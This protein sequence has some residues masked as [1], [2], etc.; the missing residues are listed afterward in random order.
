MRER[1]YDAPILFQIVEACKCGATFR[2]N[3]AVGEF[4]RRKAR[5]QFRD[6]HAGPGHGP[7]PLD[8]VEKN[9]ADWL[10]HGDL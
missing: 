1:D 5:A 4:R 9:I 10:E 6:R 3:I 2:V 7:A 8:T